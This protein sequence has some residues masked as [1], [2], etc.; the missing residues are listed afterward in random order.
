MQTHLNSANC[1]KKE[2]YIPKIYFT[3]FIKLKLKFKPLFSLFK[4]FFSTAY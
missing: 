4:N 3:S 1:W 2:Q